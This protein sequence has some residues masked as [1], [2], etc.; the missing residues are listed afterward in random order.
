M[1]TNSYLPTFRSL[2]QNLILIYFFSLI[3]LKAK[4]QDF[5]FLIGNPA[6]TDT[7][8]N[9]TLHVGKTSYYFDSLH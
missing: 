6:V 4:C 9:Y 8:T 3:S 7:N 1:K 2:F 5:Q